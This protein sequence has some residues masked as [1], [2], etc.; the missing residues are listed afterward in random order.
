MSKRKII[1]GIYKITSPTNRVYIGQSWDINARWNKYRIRADKKCRKIYASLDKYGVEAHTFEVIHE[2][3]SD[4]AQEVMDTYEILYWQL[5]KDCGIDML[6][7]REPGRGGKNSEETRALM[8]ANNW[9]AKHKG[10]LSPS[11]GKK[12]TPEH[13]AKSHPKGEKSAMYGR[14]GKDHPAFGFKQSDKWKELRRKK[15]ININTG[16]IYESIMKASEAHKMDDGHLCKLLNGKLPNIGKYKHL[17]YFSEYN[18]QN[19]T[20]GL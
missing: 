19:N 11:Y 13:I 4:T 10:E 9:N 7:I 3:P 1:S 16:E 6:N 17:Q 15:V 14:K 18:K 8:K 5:Y 2:L 20:Q 12:H